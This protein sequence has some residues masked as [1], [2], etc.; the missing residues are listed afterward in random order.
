MTPDFITKDGQSG[1]GFTKYYILRRLDA[2]K[3]LQLED[4]TRE[5]L[6]RN[7]LYTFKIDNLRRYGKLL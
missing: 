7:M 6:F 2:E 4:K 5:H 1:L 3:R